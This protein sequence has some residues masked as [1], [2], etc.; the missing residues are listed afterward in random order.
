MV[1]CSSSEVSVYD[2]ISLL[3]RLGVR[4]TP[5]RVIIT[6]I[7]LDNI[8]CHPSFKQI[9][10]KVQEELPRVGIST[11]FN[12][13]KMLTDAGVIKVFEWN[14]E[15]HIDRP[16]PHINIYCKDTGNIIDLDDH[17]EEYL[18]KIINKLNKN[19]I[20]VENLI[21]IAIANCEQDYANKP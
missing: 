5:Q 13:M 4:V 16:D 19:N 15:T 17:E 10:E 2:V 14:G 12:T 11:I 8:K 1:E 9:Y 7:I 6:K 21:V 3:G 20:N 18:K